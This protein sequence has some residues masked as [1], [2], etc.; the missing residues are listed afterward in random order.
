MQICFN[1]TTTA[2]QAFNDIL[3]TQVL[4]QGAAIRVHLCMKNLP[5]S[6]TGLV[7]SGFAVDICA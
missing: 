1:L 4:S 3:V 2:Q 7:E 6:A 5:N